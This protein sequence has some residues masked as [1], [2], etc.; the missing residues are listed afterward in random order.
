MARIPQAL[1]QAVS[2][3]AQG[4]CAY[5]LSAPD[6]ITGHAVTLFH[7]RQD[8]WLHHF[9][10][11]ADGAHIIGLTPTGRATVEALRFNRPAIVQLRHYWRTTGVQF[12][13]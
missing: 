8:V 13:E 6:P 9:A 5:C 10:W 4:R 3:A 2:G 7:P 11:S 1:R 12:G